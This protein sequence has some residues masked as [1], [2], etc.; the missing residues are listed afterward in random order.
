M[1]VYVYVCV[2][3]EPK[4]MVI[5]TWIDWFNV[6]YAPAMATCLRSKPLF[7]GF[8][9]ITHPCIRIFIPCAFCIFF[10][11][12]FNVETYVSLWNHVVVSSIILFLAGVRCLMNEKCRA[13][14]KGSL[15]FG[16]KNFCI[17]KFSIVLA[18]QQLVNPHQKVVY[19]MKIKWDALKLYSHST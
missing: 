3:Y 7:Y 15:K 12:S 16:W 11:V 10:F 4:K 19:T 6:V 5:V 1:Y 8:Y 14:W 18:F 2:D 9:F 13:I 17:V